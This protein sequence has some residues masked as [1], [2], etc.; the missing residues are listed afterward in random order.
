VSR[1]L[2]WGVP[3]PLPGWESKR[4]YVWFEACMGYLSAAAEWAARQGSPEA[5]RDFWQDEACRGYYFIG[6]DNLTFHTIRWPATLLGA[7]DLV[8]PFDVPANQ[9]VTLEGQQ[10]ST[11]RN[12]AVWMPDYLDRYD[13]D[14]LRYYLSVNMPETSDTDFTWRDYVRRNND[15]LVATWGNL[16]NRVLSLTYRN[17][18]GVVPDPG[19]LGERDLA[20]LANANQALDDVGEEIGACR[21]RAGIARAMA[22]AQETNRYLDETA[23]W[24]A[25]RDDPAAA[26]RSLYTALAVIDTVKVALAP[27]LPFSCQRLHAYLH[28]EG[29]IM[30]AGWSSDPPEAGQPLAEPKPLFLKLDPSV[31][32]EE[33]QRLG[34]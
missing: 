19:E 6:K 33:E 15:E 9:F 23:P 13:P 26:A 1:D 31:A 18:G 11:S 3:I 21:F 22:M 20:L 8:L 28:G 2:T 32:E 24:K 16:V 30:A 4:I 12:W 27:Y 29:D 5:W 17:F 14:P 10:M 7:G 34:K 25:L